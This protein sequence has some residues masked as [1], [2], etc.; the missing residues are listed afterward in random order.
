MYVHNSSKDI[1]HKYKNSIYNDI[2]KLTY[3]IMYDYYKEL[4]INITTSVL[5]T[6]SKT[7]DILAVHVNIGT[8]R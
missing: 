5:T 1:K 3:N 8:Q 6:Q 7:V 4:V 2:R